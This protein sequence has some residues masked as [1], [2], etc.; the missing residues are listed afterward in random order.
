MSSTIIKIPHTCIT[1]NSKYASFNYPNE[2][3]AL[4]C[5]SC[6]TCNMINGIHK[7]CITCNI[8]I[9]SYNYINEKQPL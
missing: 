6:K 2:K 9:P 3:E 1:C 5:K 8:R 4:Y 7:R